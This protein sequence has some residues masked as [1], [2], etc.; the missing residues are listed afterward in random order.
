[1]T[2]IRSGAV[3]EGRVP[4]R[5]FLKMAG[6]VGSAGIF[7]RTSLALAAEMVRMPFENGARRMAAFPQK[8]RLIVLRT[9]PA[10]LETPFAVFN[11]G[12]FTR[13]D[14]FYVRWHLAEVPSS[15]SVERFRLRVHGHVRTP[16]ELALSELVRDFERVDIAAVNQCSG[17]SRGFF[18]P[19]VPGGQWGNG[20]MG[21]A[22]WTGVR[23]KD[24]LDKA[25]VRPGAVSVRFKGLDRGLVPATP[26][27]MKSLSVDHA[28]DGEV[29]VA[30]GMNNQALPMLNGFPL[31]LVVPGW[32]ATYWLKALND[33]E[34]LD[35]PDESFWMKRAYLIP[36]TPGAEMKPGQADV[37]MVPISRMVPR[38]FITNVADG[39]EV[40]A[41]RSISVKGIA[42][43]GDTG[44]TKVLFSPDGGTTWRE[45]R[46]ERDYGKYSLRRFEMDFMPNQ[47]G[48]YTLMVR[49]VNQSGLEQPFK[50][51]WNPGGFMR[52]VVE[53][54]RVRAV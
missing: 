42:F 44:L 8:R 4:R 5:S 18:S 49:A 32:Y 45:V 12:V 51:N 26:D 19:R 20:A 53:R 28:M 54:V 7:A 35:K 46:L 1:M 17:N 47:P 3:T 14:A 25:G 23:L 11:D 2:E 15:V 33:I 13:N 52:N 27:Y 41:G 34:V 6:L 21:N 43:G 37:K 50:P 39:T 9:R 40:R 10:L 22:L 30:Y 48:A 16:M 38:S 31:R 29:M 36:D 24:L